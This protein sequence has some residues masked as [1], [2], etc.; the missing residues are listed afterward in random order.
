MAAGIIMDTKAD[1]LDRMVG[2]A[3]GNLEAGPKSKWPERAVGRHRNVIRLGHRSNLAYFEDSARM[4]EI[5]LDYV[6]DTLFE[7]GLEL[8]SGV[9]PFAKSDGRRRMR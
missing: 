6:Y 2:S 7:E 1:L 8:P 5:R 4:A 3:C 9:K